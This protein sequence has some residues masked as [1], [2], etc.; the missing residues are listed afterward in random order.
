MDQETLHHQNQ[1][2][3]PDTLERTQE[4]D[5]KDG[6][7]AQKALELQLQNSLHS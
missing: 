4:A 6:T 2:Q 3:K 7:M 5:R 1:P